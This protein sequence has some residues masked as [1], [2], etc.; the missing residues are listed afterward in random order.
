M[1]SNTR[2]HKISNRSAAI[3]NVP[4]SN[5]RCRRSNGGDSIIEAS[6]AAALLLPVLFIMMWVITEVSEYFVLKQQLAFVARQAA[7]EIANAYGKLGYTSMNSGGN[8]SGPANSGDA[9]YLEIINRISVPGIINANSRSQFQVKFQIPNSPSLSQAY[10]SA[11]VTYKTGPGLPKFPWN[12]IKSNF[13]SF[14]LSGVVVNSTCC[15]PIPH[16]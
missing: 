16:S 5:K 10:V 4:L 3:V 13:L 12:P 7:H 14:N 15:W 2:L 9:N 6:T 8:N 11:T 1:N